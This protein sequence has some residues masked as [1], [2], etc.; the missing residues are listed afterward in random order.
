LELYGL[1]QALNATKLWL[2]GAKKLVVE[3]DAQYIKGILNKLDPHLNATMNRWIAAILM[4]DFKLVHVPGTKHKGP[5]GLLRRVA[6]S[7]KEGE[8][9]EGAEGWI[10]EIIGTGVYHKPLNSLNH[11]LFI[12]HFLFK[13]IM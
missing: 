7:K 5:N 12:F 13:L 2:I 8:G 4:F 1:F 6:D 11:Y 3:V 9:I 10:D